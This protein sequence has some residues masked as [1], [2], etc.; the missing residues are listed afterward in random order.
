MSAGAITGRA[1]AGAG[2]VPIG[3]DTLLPIGALEFDLY[4]RPSPETPPCLYRESSYPLEQEDLDRLAAQGVDRLYIP[5]AKSGAYQTYL[6]EVVVKNEELRPAQRF[7]LLKKANRSL[8]EAAFR[9]TKATAMIEFAEEFGEQLVDVVCH[10]ETMLYRLFSVMDHDYYTYTHVTNVAAYA[11]SLAHWLHIRKPADLTSIAMGALL[12]DFG[13]RHIPVAVLNKKDRLDP[14]E[15]VVMQGH[16]TAGFDELSR[17]DDVEWGQ[18]MMVYQH[19][20]RVNGR[21]YP[22]GVTAREIEPWARICAIADVFDAL[23]SERPYRRPDPIDAVQEFLQD[24]AGTDFDREMV[25]CWVSRLRA[26]N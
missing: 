23:T 8:F 19:H 2:L 21:G 24:R 12:H 5:A 4:I 13:K 20:E 18:L 6:R 25:R 22:V 7:V 14:Q 1:S 26:A 9:S 15:R 10:R 11:V 3:V 16:V 17:R